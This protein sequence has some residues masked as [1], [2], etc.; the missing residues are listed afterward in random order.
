MAVISTVL[1]TA[2]F[3]DHCIEL[4]PARS[5]ESLSADKE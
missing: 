2:G 4:S 5:V 3:C 1:S